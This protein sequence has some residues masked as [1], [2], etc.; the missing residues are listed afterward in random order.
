FKNKTYDKLVKDYVAAIDLDSQRRTAKKI[1]ELL[2][3]EVPQL[4]TY[5]YYYLAGTRKNVGGVDI[6]AMGCMDVSRA[7]FV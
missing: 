2:L 1:Q 5:F 3:D 4:Y 6:T 7:G